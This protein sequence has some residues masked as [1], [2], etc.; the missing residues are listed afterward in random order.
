LAIAMAW[1][2]TTY[3]SGVCFLPYSP[4]NLIE[5]FPGGLIKQNVRGRPVNVIVLA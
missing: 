5:S 2:F 4:S 1:H 3:S